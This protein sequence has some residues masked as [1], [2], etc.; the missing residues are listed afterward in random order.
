MIKHWTHLIIMSV[1]LGGAMV[2]ALL[3][4]RQPVGAFLLAIHLI[5]AALFVVAGP[6]LG[7]AA[8]PCAA[9]EDKIPEHADTDVTIS[10]LSP[11]AKVIFWASEPATDGLATL[12]DWQRAYLDYANAGVATVDETGRVTLRVRKPQPYTVP[13][14]GRLDAHVHW[15]ICSDGGF[16]GPVQITPIS[17]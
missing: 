10:E 17:M 6:Y 11:G 9:L 14:L 2:V 5:A 3:Y 8:I 16:V 7:D 15:R 4:I 12:K 13:I 1:L